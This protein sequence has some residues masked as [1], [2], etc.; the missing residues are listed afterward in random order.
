MSEKPRMT[1]QTAPLQVL[2]RVDEWYKASQQKD[3]DRARALYREL[4]ED[5]IEPLELIIGAAQV[6]EAT[7]PEVHPYQVLLDMAA[8]G[9]PVTDSGGFWNIEYK[10]QRKEWAPIFNWHYSPGL[11]RFHSAEA[12]RKAIATLGDRLNV[13]LPQNPAA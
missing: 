6:P 5:G 9:P 7:K 4:K 1:R 2:T 8:E 3:A 12:A 11:V 13:L 10:S